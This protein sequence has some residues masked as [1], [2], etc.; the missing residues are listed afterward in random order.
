MTKLYIPACG[1]RLTL[2]KAWEFD[3]YLERRN[4]KF[5][6]E[7]GLVDAKF[8][9]WRDGY[10]KGADGRPEYDRGLKKVRHSLPKGA[11]LECDRVY[12]RT[13]SKSALQVGGDFDSISWKVMRG[14]KPARNQRFWVKLPDC[15]EIEY[16]QGPDSLYRDRVKAVRQ[17]MEG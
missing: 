11:V 2:T 15:Y 7:H 14:E 17:V 6:Q 1:D 5:A 12:I 4:V 9:P 3:L 8:D 16:S 13:F 10:H